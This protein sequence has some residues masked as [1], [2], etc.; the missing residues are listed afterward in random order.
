M[1]GAGGYVAG[2]VGVAALS[3]R[4][5]MVLTEADS[6]LGWP[7]HAGAVCAPRLPCLSA[8][9]AQRRP[10]RRHGPAGRREPARPRWRARA[11]FGIGPDETCVLV[12]GGSLGA[13]SLNLAALDAFA[14]ASF[15]VLHVCGQ[16]DYERCAR[17][18]FARHMTCA[19]TSTWRTSATRSPRPIW[20]SRAPG[21]VFE[22]AAYGLPAILVPY[23]HAAGDH[24]SSN[25]R[26]MSDAGAAI[27]W[28]T[29]S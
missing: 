22:M 9:R 18:R 26:W 2:P 21:S 28:P 10:L 8:R 13:R 27:T 24:Q 19:S 25:A 11:A 23:P 7:T 16:R 12:F 29:A 15:H 4:V 5:P 1:M 17:A 3:L 20:W 14:G 6:R